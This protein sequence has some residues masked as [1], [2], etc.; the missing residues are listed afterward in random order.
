MNY[1]DLD[2]NARINLKGTY[3]S[4]IRIAMERFQKNQEKVIYSKGNIRFY[5]SRKGNDRWQDRQTRSLYNSF[6]GRVNMKEGGDTLKIEFLLYGRF[7]DA[8]VGRGTDANLSL[9]RKKYGAQRSGV[10]R[11]RKKW[12]SKTKAHQQRRLAEI[13]AKYE[14]GGIVRLVETTLNQAY[15]NL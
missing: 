1:T 15:I 13:I 4:F 6:T 10:K 9:Y 5:K 12:Y 3:E 7:V 2:L 8:G 11:V 14:L